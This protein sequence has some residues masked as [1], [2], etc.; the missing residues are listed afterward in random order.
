M[1]L[2]SLPEEVRSTIPQDIAQDPAF[3]NINTIGDLM[4][5]YKE[6]SSA[7]A[8]APA[9]WTSG[10]SEDQKAI[11]QVKGWK[12]PAD[13][14]KSYAELEKH[15]G[16]DKVPLPRKD[17]NGNYEKGELERYLTAIGLPKDPTGYQ[18]PKDF[19]MPEGVEIDPRLMA[20]FSAKAHKEG[21]LPHQFNFVMQELS[22]ILQKGKDL[23]AEQNTK[24]HNDAALALRTK[25]G[26]A[27]DQ[28]ARM[29]NRV[30]HGFSGDKNKMQEIVSKFGNDPA[31]I[32]LLANVGENMSE[33]ALSQAG[34]VGQLL[35]PAAADAEIKKIMADKNN[36]YWN[37][38]HPDH[39]YWVNK[40]GELYKMKG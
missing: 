9:D 27:Y 3:A 2:E 4:K 40:M 31:L 32:E 29:A 5:G 18:L 14:I 11:L 20:D 7:P 1:F 25:W 10:L 24:A 33:D 23:Q 36:P 37:S 35:D 13:T 39:Q 21:L 28:K 22:G 8:P 12:T 17:K 19:K 38:T 16:T 26:M 30:L 6:K 15:M 34:M